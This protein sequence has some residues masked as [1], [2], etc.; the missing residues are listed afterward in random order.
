LVGIF[1]FGKGMIVVWVAHLLGLGITQ[2]VIVG[3][4]AI[5]GHNWSIFLRFN[6]GRG[7][8]TTLGIAI[9]LPLLNNLVPWGVIVFCATTIISLLITHSTP[10]GVGA[11]IAALPLVSWGLNEPVSLTL[12]YLAMFLLVV[13]KRLTVPRTSVT[14]SMSL[15]QLLLN[16]LLFDRDIRDREVWMRRAPLEAGS[17]RKSVKKGRDR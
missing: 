7:V 2:Q 12:G 14:A 16:R 17:S 1:D 8:L 5:T 15:P 4:A 3:L 10:V 6:G 13:L 9:I 11:G